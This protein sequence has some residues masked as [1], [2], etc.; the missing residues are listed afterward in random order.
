MSHSPQQWAPKICAIH[1]PNEK[2]FF[3]RI[4]GR[5]LWA[6]TKLAEAGATGCTAAQSGAA[7][8]AAYIWRL[9]QR[10]VLIE[11][12]REP[13]RGEFSGNH[14]RYILHSTVQIDIEPED[15]R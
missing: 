15:M 4:G 1:N 8:L 6:L 12:M 5:E 7:R 2:P 10:D 3:I 13:N 14:A 9:R 11:T